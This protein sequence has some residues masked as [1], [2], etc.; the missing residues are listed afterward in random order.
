MANSDKHYESIARQIGA[1]NL[2]ALRTSTGMSQPHFAAVIGLSDR[3][4]RRYERGERELPQRTRLAIIQA[5][6]IDPLASDQLAAELGFAATDLSS[7][8]IGQKT[9]DGN[10][11]KSLRRES[12]DF[13]KRNYSPLGQLFLKIRDEVYFCATIYFMMQ[14]IALAFNLP[15]GFEINGVDWMFLGSFGVIL[16]LL[17]SVVAELPILKASQYILRNSKARMSP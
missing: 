3:A 9:K 7:R 15:F 11:W 14:N 2:L 10:F 5:F 1:A 8:P 12:Q 16:L 13:R 4:L 6:K 17:P